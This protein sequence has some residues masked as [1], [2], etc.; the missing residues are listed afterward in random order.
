MRAMRFVALALAF[1]SIVAPV[2]RAQDATVYAAASLAGAFEAMAVPL[3]AQGLSPRFSFAAS[4]T[5]ARQIEQGANAD[6]FVSADEAWMDYLDGRRLLVPGTRRVIAGSRLALIVPADRARA[7]EIGRG[8]DFLALLGPSGR[9][10][11]GDPSHVPAGRYARQA[12]ESL[13][14][15]G[16]VSGRVAGAENVRVALTLVERGEAPLGVVYESDARGSARVA[17]AGF[18]PESSHA[19]VT[20]SAAIVARR[21]AAAPRAF[22]AFLESAEGKAILRRFAFTVE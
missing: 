20:F 17:I 16:S 18:F 22:L 15:W 7:I 10:A 8:T 19:K 6:L 21:D 11:M 5:L 1:A 14:L 3:R 12:F 4:S 2:A 13:G 9:I